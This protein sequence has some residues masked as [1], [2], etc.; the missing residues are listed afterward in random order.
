MPS[1]YRD[2]EAPVPNMPLRV[3]AVALI[4]RDATL[5]VE[6]RADDGT[7]GL[8]AGA[9]ENDESIVEA[10]VR[11]I[12][13][14]TRLRPTWVELFGVFSDPGRIV[15]YSDGK[16]YRV[17]ALAF[18]VRVEDGEPVSSEEALELRFTAHDELLD[19]DLTPAHRPIVEQYLAGSGRVI[20]E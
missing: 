18:R 15:G 4:E 11:E 8:V 16:V 19:L 10:L 7:W 12:D 2:P 1:W 13:E 6:R 17:L 14:E 3:G 5:L 9:L 20:V